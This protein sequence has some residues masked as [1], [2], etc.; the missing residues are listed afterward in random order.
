MNVVR[1]LE[2]WYN[3]KIQ[4]DHDERL[5]GIRY[6]GTI[7]MESFSEVLRLLGAT[8]PIWYTYHDKTRTVYIKHK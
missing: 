7:E 2:R 4:L 8:A 3:I 5:S 1:R 6:T